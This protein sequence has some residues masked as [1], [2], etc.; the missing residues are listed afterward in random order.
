MSDI[1]KSEATGSVI[2]KTLKSIKGGTKYS[3]EKFSSTCS[4][5]TVGVLLLMSK[6][7]DFVEY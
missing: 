5:E 3:A 7:L 2:P 1:W 6:A 4:L